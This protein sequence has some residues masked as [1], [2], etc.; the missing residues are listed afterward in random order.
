MSKA[1]ERALKAY[2]VKIAERDGYDEKLR[3]RK[4]FVK[5]YHQAEKD[6]GIIWHKDGLPSRNPQDS[7]FSNQCLLCMTGGWFEIGYYSFEQNAWFFP[8]GTGEPIGA[9]PKGWVELVEPK[10]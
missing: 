3:E 1:E 10:D 6:Y 7:R 5:G 8:D 4:G 2:P 9:A